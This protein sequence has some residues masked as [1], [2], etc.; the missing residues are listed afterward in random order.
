VKNI[1]RFGLA[2]RKCIFME[3][4]TTPKVMIYSFGVSISLMNENIGRYIFGGSVWF[5]RP[6]K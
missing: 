2:L 5:A 1:W 6:S 3:V 4:P